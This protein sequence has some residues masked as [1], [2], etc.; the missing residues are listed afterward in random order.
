ML[1]L[2]SFFFFL[3]FCSL[4]PSPSSSPRSPNPRMLCTAAVPCCGA[5]SAIQP[6]SVTGGFTTASGW[7]TARGASRRAATSSSLPWIGSWTRGAL[8]ASQKTRSRERYATPP[9]LLSISS[10]SIGFQAFLTPPL[11]K[12]AQLSENC[13]LTGFPNGGEGV[14]PV[15]ASKKKNK[16]LRIKWQ[17]VWA[18]GMFPPCCSTPPYSLWRKLDMFTTK[19]VFS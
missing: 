15:S 10:V 9:T 14:R 17:V 4:R 13:Q 18:R 6:T 16:S 3:Q 12:A 5:R 1:S 7:K 8:S 2:S 11:S 19:H